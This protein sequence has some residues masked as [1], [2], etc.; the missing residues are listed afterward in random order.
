MNTLRLFL[1]QANKSPKENNVFF[2]KDGLFIGKIPEECVEACATNK[3]NHRVLREW[4]ERLN[5]SFPRKMA[6]SFLESQSGFADAKHLADEDEVEVAK[7]LLYVVCR[8][9]KEGGRF[10]GLQW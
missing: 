1:K 5:F 6:E 4:V 9:I 2:D 3:P 10:E 7:M 8:D